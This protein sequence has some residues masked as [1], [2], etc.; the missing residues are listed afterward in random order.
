MEHDYLIIEEQD[1]DL[2]VTG[3]KDN[4]PNDIVIPEGVTKIGEYAF[5]KVCIYKVCYYT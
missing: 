2:V 5:N 3:F 4:A 1:K